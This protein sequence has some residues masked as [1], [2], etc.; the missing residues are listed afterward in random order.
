MKYSFSAMDLHMLLT[1]ME[2]GGSKVE[3]IYQ[4]KKNDFL[5]V[6]H[7]P[8]H[9]K[10]ILMVRLPGAM[11]L[12]DYKGE[13]PEEP[14]QFCLFLRKHLSGSRVRATEQLGFE[15]IVRMAFETKE[16]KYNLYIELFSQ[17]N[18][19]L[20]SED[21][22]IRSALIYKAWKDRT[23]R[24][25]IAYD[26]PSR[27]HN[28]LEISLDGL[29]QILAGDKE[30]VVKALALDLGLGGKYSEELCAR[31]GIVKSKK[32]LNAQEL[33]SLFKEIQAMRSS[34]TDAR[35]C[36]MEPLPFHMLT[37]EG[38]QCEKRESFSEA[39]SEVVTSSVMT[40][41]EDARREQD[42]K[43]R[44]RIEK[45]MLEQEQAIA[46]L[47]KSIVDN[48]RKGE[49]IFENYA[50]VREVLDELNKAKR[51]HSWKEIKD[52][53]KGHHTI[54]EIDEKEQQVVVDL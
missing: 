49:L 6:L 10:R 34:R 18:L 41:E 26:Y 50:V 45:M 39:V 2:L 17:G 43:A 16:A 33:E 23:I 29:N 25:G 21:G 44:K 22:I 47:Q 52:K 31:A 3:K 20:C 7:I 12:T 27:P 30:S 37:Y 48:Q 46:S 9:G 13:M 38:K 51:K 54:K 15:R 8:G 1:E 24:G 19:V 5:F 14:S 42:S 53:L 32:R 11:F 4:P 40:E 28:L 35:I 36:G